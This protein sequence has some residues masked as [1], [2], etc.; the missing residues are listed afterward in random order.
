M[1]A[2][3]PGVFLNTYLIL[4]LVEGNHRVAIK[5]GTALPTHGYIDCFRMPVSVPPRVIPILTFAEGIAYFQNILNN[6]L[7]LTEVIDEVNA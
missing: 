4:A 5:R 1:L 2:D 3:W 7:R 6:H